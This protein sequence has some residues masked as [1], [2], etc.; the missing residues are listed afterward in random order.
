MT[1]IRSYHGQ[2]VIKPPVWTW[3]IP[4]YLFTGGV[5][6]ASAELAYLSEARGN[7]VLARRAWAAAIGA[8]G[9]IGISPALPVSVSVARDGFST[10]SGWS[11]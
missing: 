5:A 3:E 9:A 2:P 4:I 1:E 11:R 7:E 10:C 6:G 8:I